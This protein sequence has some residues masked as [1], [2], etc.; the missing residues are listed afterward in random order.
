MIGISA[1]GCVQR[2][3]SGIGIFPWSRRGRAGAITR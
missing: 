3:E 1:R 2:R